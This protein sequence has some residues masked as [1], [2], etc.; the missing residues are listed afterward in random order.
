M[1]KQRIIEPLAQLK[2]SKKRFEYMSTTELFGEVRIKELKTMPYSEYLQTSEWQEKRKK[3]LKYALYRCQM[4]NAAEHL[5]V[6]HRTYERRGNED[7][8]DLTVLC[9]SCH[10]HF[11]KRTSNEKPQEHVHDFKVKMKKG[12]TIRWCKTCEE[13]HILV[14]GDKPHWVPMVLIIEE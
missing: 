9:R 12:C 7:I 10:D 2:T 6:H 14:Q 8:E 5:D 4:C 13:S 11:H 1:N 3:A